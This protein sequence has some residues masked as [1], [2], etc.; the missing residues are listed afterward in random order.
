[1][2]SKVLQRGC[3]YQKGWIAWDGHP[4]Q[5]AVVFSLSKP[6]KP[7]TVSG[8]KDLN[9]Q[10]GTERVSCVRR[11][12]DG[13]KDINLGA[14]NAENVFPDVR[15]TQCP[16]CREQAGGVRLKAGKRSVT[17]PG[18]APNTLKLLLWLCL[19]REAVGSADTEVGSQLQGQ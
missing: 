15:C 8:V 13:L 16:L 18:T 1:M 10:G 2:R 9:K 11:G 12:A 4:E 19:G 3:H 5:M 14:S 7:F 6:V 17:R